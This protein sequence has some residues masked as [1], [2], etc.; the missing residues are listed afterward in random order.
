MG[1]IVPD[2]SDGAKG[3]LVAHRRAL[4]GL[5]LGDAA[6]PT[7]TEAGP[8]ATDADPA[9]TEADPTATEADPTATEAAPAA[10]E[11]SPTAT[12]ASPTATDAD[13]TATAADPDATEADPDATEADPDAT[14]ADPDATEAGPTATAPTAPA[15][16][17]TPAAVAPAPGLGRNAPGAKDFSQ[18]AHGLLLQSSMKLRTGF[19]NYSED[20]LFH[21]A[22]TVIA[23]LTGSVIFAGIKPTVAEIQ[24]ATDAYE[25]ALNM[26]GPGRKQA[27]KATRTTLEGLLAD[28]A[29]NAP[30]VPNVTPSDLATL[31]IPEVKPPVRTT[32]VP[33]QPL[34]FRLKHGIMSGVVEAKCK[35]PGGNIRW[36]VIEWTLDPNAGVWTPAGTS[37][38]SQKI[39]IEDLPRGKDIWV[40]IAAVNVIGQGAWSDPATI[41]V[42]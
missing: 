34:D 11:A 32:E 35:A 29:V 14:E 36:F 6:A 28:V 23:A 13:P 37:T 39:S 8:T 20:E 17:L 3:K 12:D 2:R 19:S 40:R 15:P 25:A 4:P 22:V 26:V 27:V 1:E 16:P 33:T 9:A 18:A 21:L 30:Q 41:M 24:A 31:G 5:D 10:T 42:I 7:A 38:S